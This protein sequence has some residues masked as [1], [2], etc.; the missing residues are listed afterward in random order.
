MDF[1]LPRE[2]GG[3]AAVNVAISPKK[4]RFLTLDALRG[5]GA[6][7]VMAGHAGIVLNAY[8]P[9]FMHLAVDMFFVLSGFVLAHAYDG[10]FAEGMSI[11][12]FLKARVARLY[13][14]YL[15]G[16][17]LGLISVAF[18][19]THALAPARA[20]LS[21]F[22]GLL[23]LP[24]PPMEP[25]GVLF[26]LNGPFWSLFFEF[27]IA[28]LIFA[29]FWRQLRGR[30]LALIIL[31]SAGI[32]TALGLHFGS[33][34]FGWTWHQLPGG[35]AR[36]CYSFFAG[37]ALSRFHAR[38]T[39]QPVV[40]SWACLMVFAVV[41]LLPLQG[42]TKGLYEVAVVLLIFP[43]LI[44]FGAGAIERR[45]E[46]GKALGDASYAIYAVHRPLLT[47]LLWPLSLVWSLKAHPP[48]PLRYF[49]EILLMAV[50]GIL[51]WSINRW[52]V[53]RKG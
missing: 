30:V 2:Q 46:I 12:A 45:P 34:D 21:F 51:A 11:E 33:L 3:I 17:V 40:P 14:T 35:F 7:A 48:Q 25:L 1:R 26:P 38:Q 29:L 52:L 36:V 53:F 19:N 28:N 32:L 41:M 8:M 47:I 20:L 42:F 31:V 22:F 50:I 5:L 18:A 37:V 27:W 39:R 23:A 49:F 44:Y 24:S 10:K 6:I 13:P 9:P 4:T 43:A 15:V 16:L